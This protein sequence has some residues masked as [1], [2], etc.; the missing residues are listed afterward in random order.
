MMTG[1]G[2]VDSV[3]RVAQIDYA[4]AIGVEGTICLL[5]LCVKQVI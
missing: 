2:F 1:V 3:H 4:V 5:R